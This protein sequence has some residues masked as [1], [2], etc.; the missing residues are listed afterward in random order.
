VDSSLGV[1]VTS[2]GMFF[3]LIFSCQFRGGV[4]PLYTP[5]IHDRGSMF[6][7]AD[8]HSCFS[9]GKKKQTLKMFLVLFREG[10]L[11]II[12]I[13]SCC[14]FPLVNQLL[15]TRLIFCFKYSGNVNPDLML[16]S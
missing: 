6:Q 2:P 15:T 7:Q 4:N 3:F 12:N 14:H 16:K 10:T 5:V 1:L 11:K 9:S 13:I 8:Y